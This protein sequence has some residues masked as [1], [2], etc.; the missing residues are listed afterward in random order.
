MSNRLAGET[1]PYLLQHAH[2]PVDWHPW[3]D[4]AFAQA[5][6]EEK[7]VFLSIGYSSCHWCHVMEKESFENAAIADLLN[8]HFVSIKVDREERPDVDDVYM[9][10]V[11]LT[12][13]RGG[14]PL[15]AFLLPD[16]KP[17]FAGTYFP[18]E[19]RHGRAGFKTLL[20][21]I[22]QAWGNE[23]A[24]LEDSAARIAGE[25]AR[26]ADP[27]GSHT[28][29]SLSRDALLLPGEALSRAFDPRHGGFGSAPK[30]PP[31]LAL[32]WLLARGAAGDAAALVHA[33]GTLDG[34]ALGGIRD[35]LGGGFHRYSTDA[36]WLLP[37]FEKMLTDNAQ[38]LGVYARAYAV[39]GDALYGQVAR[40]TGDYLLREMRG[41]EGG[42]YAATDADSEGE[43][44]KY[45]CW[46]PAQIREC[47]GESDGRFFCEW[48]GVREGGNFAEEATGHGTGASV[49][50]LSKK[51]SSTPGAEER[52]RPLRLRLL[53]A[54][55][56]RIPP[57]LDD[58][59]VAGWNA[60][61]VSGFAVA[62]RALGEPRYLEAARVGAR[63]LLNVARLPDGVLARTWKD[64]EAKIPAFLEDEAFLA[65]SLLDL[66]DAEGPGAGGIW[67]DEA[68]ASAGSL[69]ER[70]R[71]KDGPGFTFSGVGNETLLASGRDL[72]DKAVPSASGAAARALARLA[73]ATG[74]RVLAKE[75]KHAVDEVGWLMS[76]SP[77]GTESWFFALEALFEFEDR[78]GEGEEEISSKVNGGEAQ[79]GPV[80]VEGV[81]V[82]PKVL[83]GGKGAI[84]LRISVS[85]GWHLQ[86]PDGLRIEA[87]GGS[88]FTFEEIPLPEPL[89][90]TSSAHDDETGWYGIFEANLSFSVSRNASKGRKEIAVRVAHRACGEGACRP[91]A[92]L[93]LSIPLEIC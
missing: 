81:A 26:A 54:R 85:P 62:A 59:R 52:L 60:L 70:F 19:D 63:F 73:L 22:A 36:E 89:K 43:E 39:T 50:F 33:V 27:A 18:P 49:L 61:A 5:R 71:R 15:S 80:R 93:L 87:W 58:K 11:Q 1:S 25:V 13:G 4:E 37:H 56:K 35:H 21:R 45:F 9:T 83:R 30:F 78:Y 28:S 67:H 10:A 92:A 90:L 72:F 3:G 17:F 82:E 79:A 20:L 48:Y 68:R 6:R 8:E 42:F 88:E 51:I 91:E 55:A 14:W 16:G 74:D 69:L 12:T 64:G 66:A 47:L 32:E 57:A 44:G 77:H 31:H 76:R 29:A 23:R 2:N 84:R 34:M 53:D 7:P 38:L 86:W 75:A 24:A 46:D 41:T 65:L 40:E